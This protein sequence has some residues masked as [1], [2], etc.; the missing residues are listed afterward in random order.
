MQDACTEGQTN[1][2]LSNQ[3][4]ANQCNVTVIITDLEISPPNDKTGTHC[5]F[6]GILS[7]ESSYSIFFDNVCTWTVWIHSCPFCPL[8]QSLGKDFVP[9][10]NHWERR[11][12]RRQQPSVLLLPL[13]PLPKWHL[14]H[15]SFMPL[16]H[17]WPLI[18]RSLLF[19]PH[20]LCPGLMT[21]LHS[22]CPLVD[23]YP[24]LDFTQTAGPHVPY[25][26]ILW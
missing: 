23:N 9:C 15:N 18:P 19:I 3:L 1:S 4:A 2:L 10:C 14:T 12:E 6:G 21:L 17:P 5:H 26:E 16:T 25:S 11:K 22:A 7:P 13:P 24:C 20:L 8:L